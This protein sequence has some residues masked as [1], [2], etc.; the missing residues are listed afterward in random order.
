MNVTLSPTL[1]ASEDLNSGL[2]VCAT[3]MFS[4]RTTLSIALAWFLYYKAAHYICKILT[5]AKA[6]F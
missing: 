3:S 2:C 5:L 4:H 6:V 1:T